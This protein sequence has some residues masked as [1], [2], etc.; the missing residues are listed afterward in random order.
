M[1]TRSFPKILLALAVAGVAA[2][3]LSLNAG[4]AHPPTVG[5][6]NCFL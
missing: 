4:D 1:N 5:G 6:A 2:S 3:P